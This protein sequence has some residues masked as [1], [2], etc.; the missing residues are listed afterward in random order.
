MLFLLYKVGYWERRLWKG[1]VIW[2]VFSVWDY[3]LDQLLIQRI[4]N[5]LY[6]NIKILIILQFFLNMYSFSFLWEIILVFFISILSVC[7]VIM[8]TDQDQ[9]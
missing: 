1:A 2:L 7:K 5:I 8:E 4:Q 3:S 9:N 6:S